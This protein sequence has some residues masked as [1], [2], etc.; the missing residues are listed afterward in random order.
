VSDQVVALLRGMNTGVK[1]RFAMA[2]LRAALARAGLANP[3]TLLASGNVVVEAPATAATFER[4]ISETFGIEMPVI[5]RTGAELAAVLRS[6]PFAE[7][8]TDGAKHLVAF[9]A[10]PIDADAVAAKLGATD[11]GEDRW[12]VRGRE[13]YLWLP[14]GMGRSPLAVA[15]AKPPLGPATTV[16]N[17]NTI[18]KLV[19]MAG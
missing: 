2:D 13:L 19:R 15:V 9:A 10:E 1:N 7:V 18:G 6:S 16:R 12:A 4:V 8:A 11:W 3:R 14:D 5:T 17:A